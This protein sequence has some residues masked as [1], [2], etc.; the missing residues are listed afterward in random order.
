MNQYFINNFIKYTLLH[1]I[2]TK[3]FIFNLKICKICKLY[4]LHMASI[5]IYMYPNYKKYYSNALFL[6]LKQ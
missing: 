2:E 3:K 5:F 1:S 4:L 6:I